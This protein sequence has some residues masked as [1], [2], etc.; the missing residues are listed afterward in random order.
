MSEDSRA[1]AFANSAT[2]FKHPVAALGRMLLLLVKV[3]EISP[4]VLVAQDY[5]Q[6]VDNIV[7]RLLTLAKIHHEMVEPLAQVAM[8]PIVELLLSAGSE[9]FRT[10][11]L[12]AACV[13]G[14]CKAMTSHVLDT[15][16]IT[17][18]MSVGK[19]K[20]VVQCLKVLSAL[21]ENE[22]YVL[23]LLFSKN[24]VG[25]G[26][27][28]QGGQAQGA[29][30]EA[31]VGGGE[32]AGKDVDA[33]GAATTAKAIDGGEDDE[34][35]LFSPAFSL[36]GLFG[37]LNSAGAGDLLDTVSEAGFK[38]SVVEQLRRIVGLFA[39]DTKKFRLD[40]AKLFGDRNVCESVLNCLSDDPEDA[41][42]PFDNLYAGVSSSSGPLSPPIVPDENRRILLPR[43]NRNLLSVSQVFARE[44]LKRAKPSPVRTAV[45]SVVLSGGGNNVLSG[46][47]PA[48]HGRG[49]G[50]GAW[51][52]HA[53][54]KD[55]RSLT[56]SPDWQ[57][58]AVHEPILEKKGNYQLR[59][60]AFDA[61]VERHKKLVDERL[62]KKQKLDEY[63][64]GRAGMQHGG[65]GPHQQGGGPGRGGISG[66]W[67]DQSADFSQYY[68]RKKN[69]DKGNHPLAIGYNQ[70]GGGPGGKMLALR[71]QVDRDFMSKVTA[72]AGGKMKKTAPG[73]AAASSSQ[74]ATSSAAAGAVSAVQGGTPSGGAAGKTDSGTAGTGKEK[75]AGK[76]E[77][78]TGT[79]APA[80]TAA[81]AVVSKAGGVPPKGGVLPKGG[82]D[83]LASYDRLFGVEAPAAKD[84]G[85]PHS[86]L[87]R[88]YRRYYQHPLRR[89]DRR[90]EACRGRYNYA[91]RFLNNPYQ[92][93]TVFS[94][95][96]PFGRAVK[97]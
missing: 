52:L 61:A 69:F 48:D 7:L 58:F 26:Q 20:L 68:R 31:A 62:L 51:S 22:Q 50:G 21:C 83:D 8:R 40:G 66:Y 24:S 23:H 47:A 46:V 71:N 76:K 35:F 86:V 55:I 92:V 6:V 19:Q 67:E 5:T 3:A 17:E 36:A 65:G 84:E 89:R 30:S 72:G 45:R 94:K 27:G 79:P 28:G 49:A 63:Q 34:L 85:I 54:L 43:E 41:V 33:N 73:A 44:H 1:A 81:A 77:E 59:D 29:S 91:F 74:A 42:Y 37:K 53:L 88:V 2:F 9:K 90:H 82:L 25:E 95:Y 16:E 78:D 12:S 60:F 80:G 57:R 15:V 64:A 56:N 4:D 10:P 70:N 75:A 18:E 39:A 32:R 87:E 93:P 11:I 14:L 38:Q 97:S 96:V 13:R